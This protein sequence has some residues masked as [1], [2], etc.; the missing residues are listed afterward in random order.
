MSLDSDNQV[1]DD[2]QLNQLLATTAQWPSDLPVEDLTGEV[3]DLMMRYKK[4]FFHCPA[5]E[6]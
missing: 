4:I 2:E 6:Y 1:V 5:F 3:Q